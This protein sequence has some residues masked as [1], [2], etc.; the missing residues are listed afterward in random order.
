MSAVRIV[1]AW[2]LF[3]VAAQA[4]TFL[5][6]ASE[7]RS[8][9]ASGGINFSGISR[10]QMIQRST[11]RFSATTPERWAKAGSSRRGLPPLTE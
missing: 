6:W 1:A 4:Q 11:I 10:Q 5:E 8:L 7:P 2:L 9:G 3:A